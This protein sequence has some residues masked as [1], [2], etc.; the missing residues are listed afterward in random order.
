MH[1]SAAENKRLMQEIF[2][3]LSKGNG[4]PFVESMADDFCWTIAGKTTWS[5]IYR[6]KEAV[7]TE[8][9]GPLFSR[10]A[11]RYM[12]T[13]H[14]FIA[15]GDY[16]VVECQGR[17]TTKEGRPY[18][19]TYCWVCRI[20]GGKLRELTEYMDTELVTAALGP[21]GTV[22]SDTAVDSPKGE[23]RAGKF[24][25]GLDGVTF[26]SEGCR[27]LGGL[28]R[29]AG[30]TPRPTAVL[31]H[32]LPGIE[33]HLDIAYRLRDLGWNCLYFHFRGCWGSEGTFSLAGLADDTRAAVEWVM[34]QPQVDKDRVVLIGASTGTHP[35]LICGSTDPRIRA[36][37]GV[38]PL[39]EPRAFQFPEEMAQEF[40]GML[41]GVAGQDLREQWHALPPLADSLRAFAPRPLLLVAA[42]KDSIF[43]HS[44]YAD[45]IAGLGDI[46]LICDEESDHGFS[47]SRQWLAQTVTDWLVARFGT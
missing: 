7:L 33:K 39:I 16:V 15:E 46:Q 19:N 44:H 27:L 18:N 23:G 25:T 47:A 26:T 42:G 34:K 31:L 11:D 5:G 28:Y 10:F 4:K 40:A 35:A 1:M 24:E 29:A 13:A 3:E 14:R 8:L 36:I 43:P 30:D 41:S 12:N 6:G 38:S 20:G 17:V 22:R 32:G 21:R 2:S 37:V 9:L 45:S